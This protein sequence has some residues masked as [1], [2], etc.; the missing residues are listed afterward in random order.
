M[1]QDRPSFASQY[2]VLHVYVHEMAELLL[3]LYSPNPQ[4]LQRRYVL[5]PI[6][7]DLQEQ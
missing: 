6:L 2:R 4:S 3:N 7:G 1:T 5:F